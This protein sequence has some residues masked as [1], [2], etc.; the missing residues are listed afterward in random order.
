MSVR[1]ESGFTLVEL[2]VALLVF[3]ML[4]GAGVMLLRFSVDAQASAK[5]RLDGIAANRRIESLLA[6]DAAQAMPRPTRNGAGDVTPS[7]EGTPDR[8][9]LV[10]GGWDNLDGAPRPSLQRVEYRLVGNRLERRQWPMLDGAAPDA[11][12]TLVDRVSALRLRY[13][14]AEGWRDRWDALRLDVL[15]RAVEL[16]VRRADGPE[17]RYVFL[18]GA[19][20]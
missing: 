18:V 2:L 11:A 16:T 7:F 1:G 8:F 3:G 20:A 12:A 4:A 6:A 19:G 14:S 15:P 10:R 9:A 17:Y 5:D 13:R